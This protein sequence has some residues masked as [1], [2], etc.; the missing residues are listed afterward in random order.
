[1]LK[2]KIFSKS[3]LAVYLLATMLSVDNVIA[4]EIDTGSASTGGEFSWE[5]SA[6]LGY[7][8][9]IYMAPDGKYNDYFYSPSVPVDPVTHSGFFIPVKLDGVYDSPVNASNYLTTNYKFTGDF[10]I[11]R[12]YSNADVSSHTINI[13]DRYVLGEKGRL[14]DFIYGGIILIKK[15]DEYTERDTGLDKE[16]SALANVSARYNYTAT[17]VELEYKQRTSKTKY[18]VKFKRLVRNYE[19]P[20][21]I[22]ELDHTY[23]SLSGDVKFSLNR[24][25]KLKLKYKHSIYDYDDRHSRDATGTYSNSFPLLEYVYDEYIVSYLYKFSRDF[26]MYFDYS[27]KTRSDEYVGYH[28]YDR[29]KYKV[30]A[31][32]DYSKDIA[33]KAVFTY[34]ERDYP[35]A[36][37]FDNDALEGKSYDSVKLEFGG[38]YAV[39]ENKTYWLDFEWRDENSTDKRYEYD[40]MKIMAGV[41]FSN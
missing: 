39:T 38:D 36:F 26:N 31:L 33:L 14:Q 32:Y 8:S 27:F 24:A 18:G 9:N 34:W 15:K 23:T 25:S 4:A 3:A 35:N 12:D 21:A 41:K 40:R 19:D 6:G 7:D 30:R 11:D 37:A 2:D 29:N 22:S 1:M 10:Y 20:V 5:A 17:G 28:D 16:T 13:G